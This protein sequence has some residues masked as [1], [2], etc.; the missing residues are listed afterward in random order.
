MTLGQEI[1]ESRT[2][3]SR[4]RLELHQEENRLRKL[5]SSCTHEREAFGAII[6]RVDDDV[7]THPAAR[8]LDCGVGSFLSKKDPTRRSYPKAVLRE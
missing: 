1:A 6:I 3:I 2:K 7:I 4:L 8:C 5:E